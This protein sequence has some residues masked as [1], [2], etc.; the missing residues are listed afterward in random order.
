VPNSISPATW[1]D[2]FTNAYNSKADFACAVATNSTDIV[3]K[4]SDG[5]C[6]GSV[7]TDGGGCYHWCKPRAK[8]LTDWA[9]CISDKVYT[10]TNFGQACNAPGDGALQSAEQQGEAAPAGLESAGP[11][12][13]GVNA[14]WKLGAILG[15]I[16]LG[17][18][19]C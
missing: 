14:S 10:D 7:N 9:T 13:V 5:C 12:S 1:I 16:R 4:M 2:G 19:M 17:K 18:A 11:R 15:I 3:E 8:D 6:K